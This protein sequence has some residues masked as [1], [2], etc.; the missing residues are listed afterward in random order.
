MSYGVDFTTD[1]GTE[2]TFNATKVRETDRA[3]RAWGDGLLQ[4]IRDADV[5]HGV[6]P[7]PVIEPIERTGRGSRDWGQKLLTKIR[8]ARHDVG[9]TVALPTLERDENWAKN[10]IGRIH[11]INH[12]AHA[13][14]PASEASTPRD[15]HYL[16]DL[17]A[18]L[19]N[20]RISHDT[21]IDREEWLSGLTTEDGHPLM[22]A[23]HIWDE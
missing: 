23:S 4:M 14:A 19:N 8:A 12:R 22:P 17:L 2:L 11:E 16:L 3:M 7:P 18:K 21:G 9:D 13:H 10:V 20:L 15:M 5:R 6:S 1:L